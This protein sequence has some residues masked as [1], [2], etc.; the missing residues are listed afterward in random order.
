MQPPFSRAETLYKKIDFLW[1]RERRL[2]SNYYMHDIS[3]VQEMG[4]E[5]YDICY[6]AFKYS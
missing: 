2:S 4:L 6:C 3:S 5:I 1:V